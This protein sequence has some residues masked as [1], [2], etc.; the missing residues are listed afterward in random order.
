MKRY[1]SSSF[2]NWFHCIYS[3]ISHWFIYPWTSTY[4]CDDVSGKAPESCTGEDIAVTVEQLTI[5][6]RRSAEWI[7]AKQFNTTCVKSAQL[8]E[9]FNLVQL[10]EL[11]RWTKFRLMAHKDSQEGLTMCRT[12]LIIYI[13]LNRGGGR[14]SYK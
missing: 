7:S 3:F 5:G 12:A 1:V 8:M 13:Y 4:E 2:K 11:L 6:P 10:S 9:F 14:G